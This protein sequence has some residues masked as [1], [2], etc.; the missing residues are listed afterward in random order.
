MENELKQL[1]ELQK[2]DLEIDEIFE[3]GESE[4]S[5]F[6]QL[7]SMHNALSQTLEA[8]RA[9]LEETRQLMQ[10]KVREL[11]ENN[12]NHQAHKEK[13]AKVTTSKELS[14]VEKELDA[15]RRRKAQL[16][17]EHDQ[18][19]EAVQDAEDDVEEKQGR[20]NEI[21]AELEQQRAVIDQQVASAQGRVRELETLRDELKKNFAPGPALVA[22]RRYE[23][24]RQRMTGRVIVVAR[25]G[26]CSGCNM[27]IPPQIYNELQDGK[28]FIQCPACKRILYYEEPI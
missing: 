28:K 13:Q 8:K 7:V 4:K 25:A 1:R 3:R 23:F 6:E 16:E 22:L 24:I 11:A 14:A 12:D 21:A 9:E 26:A 10:Q 19:R 18:L 5:A 17:E 27:L 2:Y 15:L 20:T